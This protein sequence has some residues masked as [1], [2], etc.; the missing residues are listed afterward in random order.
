MLFRLLLSVS[1][2]GANLDTV[3]E[4]SPFRRKDQQALSLE[5]QPQSLTLFLPTAILDR[6]HYQNF[7]PSIPSVESIFPNVKHDVKTIETLFLEL[8][9]SAEE[10][11]FEEL[12]SW[13]DDDSCA[14]DDDRLR[15]RHP[16]DSDLQDARSLSP[17]TA[18]HIPHITITPCESPA[19]TSSR[20]PLQD[21]ACARRLT[22]PSYTVVNSVFPP[23]RRPSGSLHD[24]KDWTWKDGHWV[25]VI[26][27]LE[28]Q[29]R[30][31]LYARPKRV[32]RRQSSISTK[33]EDG[34]PLQF[35]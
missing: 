29:A 19:D 27:S 8:A 3:A 1:T 2:H 23:M 34:A 9:Q 24:W 12:D 15:K 6:F 11:D 22:V 17:L 35:P 30:R 32:R 5:I 14:Y 18:F 7:I 20:I 10:E 31:G 13:L 25:A 16:K 28:D 21:S 33:L 26:P 4:E